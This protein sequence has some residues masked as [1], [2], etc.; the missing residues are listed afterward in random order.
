MKYE[1][2]L[3]HRKSIRLK[4]YNYSQAGAYYITIITRNRQCLFGNINDGKMMMNN[5]GKM[6]QTI[7]DEMPIYYDNIEIDAFIVMPN[8]IHGI[9]NIVGTGPCACP[10]NYNHEICLYVL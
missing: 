3:Y 10:D 1:P 9:I 4:N 7:W 8:H 6:I 5:A 2:D